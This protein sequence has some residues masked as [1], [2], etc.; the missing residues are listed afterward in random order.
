MNPAMAHLLGYDSPHELVASITDIS[1]QIY[2]DPTSREEL[3]RLLREQEL[4]KN[5][6]CAV[7]RK[8]GSKM[9]FSANVRAVSED[10]VLVGYEGTNED[11]TA[12]KARR[13]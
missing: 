8:D 3:A 2:V 12:R 11:I 7:Y 9:W 4:V 5:F 1:Q 10:G 13:W 6:E